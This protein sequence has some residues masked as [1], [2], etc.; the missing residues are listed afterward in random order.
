MDLLFMLLLTHM[1]LQLLD[2]ITTHISMKL[3]LVERNPITYYLVKQYGVTGLFFLKNIGLMLYTACSM[4]SHSTIAVINVTI[5]NNVLALLVTLNT[6]NIV[7][8]KR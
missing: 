3:R 7:L 2:I 4:M 5:A 1:L 6:I 8:K